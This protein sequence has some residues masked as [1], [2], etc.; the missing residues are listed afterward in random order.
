MNRL[1]TLSLSFVAAALAAGLA[2][3]QVPTPT[4]TDVAQAPPEERSSAGAIVLENSPVRAQRQSK[5]FQRT[6]ARR[7][8]A[9][10]GRH[11]DEVLAQARFQR[12]LMEA[13]ET[14][15]PSH[16]SRMGGPPEAPHPAL[17]PQ[18]V[19]GEIAR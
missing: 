2:Q 4:V 6:A 19:P 1:T 18:P 8:A 12:A 15:P 10:V 14:S 13:M 16:T 11:A 17:P 7:D 5:G 3:A 9:P